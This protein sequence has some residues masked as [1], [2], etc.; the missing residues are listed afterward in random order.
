MMN[1][2]LLLIVPAFVA[3]IFSIC[4]KITATVG[5]N[6]LLRFFVS[7]FFIAVSFP[8]ER[9]GGTQK[10]PAAKMN[11][12]LQWPKIGARKQR[13][14]HLHSKHSLFCCVQNSYASLRPYSAIR[15]KRLILI[16]QVL[17]ICEF[18]YAFA[19]FFYKNVELQFKLWYSKK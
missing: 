19:R 10:E 14:E 8:S 7:L 13:W 2:A 15:T 16:K 3:V 5:L 12:R 4:C 6:P 17:T 11:H 18:V 1:D 9:D